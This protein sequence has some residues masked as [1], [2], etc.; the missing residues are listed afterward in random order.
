MTA[1]RSSEAAVQQR[2]LTSSSPQTATLVGARL[3]LTDYEGTLDWIAATVAARERGYICLCSVH[4]V[5]AST[6]DAELR[7]ALAGSSFNV[8]DG[9]PLVWAL[10]ALGHRVSG[11][12]YGPELIA[13]AC[14]RAMSGGQRFYLYGGRNQGALVQLAL[15][16]RRRYPGVKIVGGYSPPY[17]PLTDDEEAALAAEI[18]RT[19]ADVVWVGIGAPKQEKWMA[20][21][22]PRLQAPMMVGVGA[23]F[24]IHAGLVPQA[25]AWLQR[26]GLEWAYRLAHEPRR[27]WR[28]YLRYNPRFVAAFGRQLASDRRERAAHSR[29]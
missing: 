18:D 16:L 14:S 25:P 26:A 27:L 24:D 22:R 15:N 21:M 23:A 10:R 2:R 29:T 5:M 19:R 1:L 8:P 7:A 11:R 17:R 9:Q 13:R 20:R 4:N 3:A 12:V 6:E 28:R